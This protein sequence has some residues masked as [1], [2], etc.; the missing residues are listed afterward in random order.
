[1]FKA[2]LPCNFVCI[3]QAQLLILYSLADSLDYDYSIMVFRF[4]YTFYNVSINIFINEKKLC[5]A[6][7]IGIESYIKKVYKY[8][9]RFDYC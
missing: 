7:N 3:Y 2:I 6:S 8:S 4:R 1:M 9:F 5:K